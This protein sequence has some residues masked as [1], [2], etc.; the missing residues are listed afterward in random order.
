VLLGLF[1][2]LAIVLAAVGIYGVVSYGVSQRR[3]EFGL[4]M[5]LGAQ[6]RDILGLVLGEGSR[7]ALA[8]VLAGLLCAFLLTRFMSSVLY[9]VGPMDP[10][11][12]VSFAVGL[13]C[14]ALLACYLSA[15]RATRTDPI[16]ALRNE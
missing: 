3:G 6:R 8:G 9:N 7:I 4:R 10:E 15:R 5:A 2:S 16:V 11:T 1:S 13:G 14:V 12:Y